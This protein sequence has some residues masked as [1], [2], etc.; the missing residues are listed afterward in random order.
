[1]EKSFEKRYAIELPKLKLGKNEDEFHV[2]NTFFQEF[3]YGLI[4]EGTLDIQADITKYNTHLDV[5]FSFKGEVTLTC[6]RC[7]EPYSHQMEFDK[8]V[9]F[10]YD[11]DLEFNTDEVIQITEEEPLLFLAADFYDFINLEVPL[12]KV[13]EPEVHECP[14]EVLALLE[15]ELEEEESDDEDNIDPR[16]EA[17]KK[18]KN[19]DSN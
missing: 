13:P 5:T 14:P 10:A 17:L 8:R 11:E 18:L 7:L 12:R 15:G 16:W 1:M 9:I 4:E 2:D 19:K 6:D 3:E